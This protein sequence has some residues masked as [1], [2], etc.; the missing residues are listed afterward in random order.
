MVASF[1]RTEQTLSHTVTLNDPPGGNPLKSRDSRFTGRCLS[2]QI[3][4]RTIM[5]QDRTS[6]TPVS[7]S[8][9]RYTSHAKTACDTQ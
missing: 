9:P 5:I 1:I 3:A 8:E 2:F 4:S 6:F 7:H